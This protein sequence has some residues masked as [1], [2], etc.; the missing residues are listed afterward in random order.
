[1][2]QTPLWVYFLPPLIAAVAGF[3]LGKVKERDQTRFVRKI[4]ALNEIRGRI[5]DIKSDLAVL[6]DMHSSESR[7]EFSREFTTKL[8]ELTSYRGKQGIW[9]TT[10]IT[11]KVDPILN[12]FTRVAVNLLHDEGIHDVTSNLRFSAAID[13]AEDLEVDE[14]IEDLD[15]QA[16]D[17]GGAKI[18]WSRAL[19][20]TLWDDLR[21]CIMRRR[22]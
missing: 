2:T 3:Y 13:V 5:Y 7:K 14:L 19:L 4:D 20:L 17:L 16:A 21:R 8:R 6:P 10:E 9:L 22:R 1:M 18:S 12:G 11:S 15:S